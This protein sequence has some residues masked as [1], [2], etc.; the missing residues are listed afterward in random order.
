MTKITFMGA[1]SSV[2]ARNVLGDC[3]L[4]ESLHDAEIALYDID[5]K[6]IAESEYILDVL[7][8]NINSSRARITSYVGVENRKAALAD[9]DVVIN[10]IQVGGYDPA[11]MFSQ[12]VESIAVTFEEVLLGKQSVLKRD[13]Q[14]DV[15]LNGNPAQLERLVSV[16]TENASKYV[17]ENGEVAVTLRQAARYTHLTIFT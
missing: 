12:V 8:K 10:A 6:R 15:T 14:P 11:M 5:A 9:T 3:M 4:Q 1:G 7:N 16:L 17:S 13:I 2:F